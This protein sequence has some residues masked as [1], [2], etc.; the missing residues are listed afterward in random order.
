M[1]GMTRSYIEKFLPIN[2]EGVKTMG[3]NRW[4]SESKFLY[5]EHV[6]Y[7]DEHPELATKIENPIETP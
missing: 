7:H 6:K 4:L 3:Y 5:D 2:D 1:G